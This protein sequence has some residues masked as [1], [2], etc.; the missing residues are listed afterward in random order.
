MDMEDG[1]KIRFAKYE[2]IPALMDF[3]DTCWKK[4]HIMGKN[5]KLF[6]FQHLWGEEIS[7]VMAEEGGQIKGVLGFIPYD[8]S[9]RDVTLAIWKTVKTS[10][11]MLGIHILEFL[12]KNGDVKSVSAPGINSRTISIYQFLGMNTGRM[13]HWYR[14]KK[15]DRYKIARITDYGIPRYE[16]TGEPEISPILGWE[17][18]AGFPIAQCLKRERQTYKSPDFIRRR[19]FEHPVFDYLKYGVRLGNKKMFVVMRIQ[20]CSGSNALRLIDCIGDHE[21]I[22]FLTPLLDKLMAH[23]DCEYAD[24]YETGIDEKIFKNGGWLPVGENGNVIPEYFSPFEQ[25][26]VVIH[27]M[28]EIDDV[29]LFKGDG[30]MDRP[31]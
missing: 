13:E 21:L 20:P 4:G 8:N 26:N 11:T 14:L 2:D 10:D 25:K 28:S 16:E 3:I 27:Y 6:E 15:C 24:C 17:A 19:Y 30:D 5:R 23:L 29:I 12:R 31:N 22:R 1:I 7:F 9:S 18:A